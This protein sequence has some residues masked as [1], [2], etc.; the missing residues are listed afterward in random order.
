MRGAS[1][2]GEKLQNSLARGTKITSQ[3]F[4]PCLGLVLRFK[5]TE[6]F[7]W[8]F[9]IW[10]TCFKLKSKI[11]QS[12]RSRYNL[13][14]LTFGKNKIS[15]LGFIRTQC[16]KVQI[17]RPA[18]EYAHVQRVIWWSRAAKSAQQSRPKGAKTR[19]RRRRGRRSR[20]E[21]RRRRSPRKKEA[22]RGQGPS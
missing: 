10:D 22:S 9:K 14:D 5:F 2:R 6:F 18:N 8:F 17:F 11:K 20:S 7:S 15:R 4:N 3:F 16:V 12:S 19:R 21:R 1:E 13:T